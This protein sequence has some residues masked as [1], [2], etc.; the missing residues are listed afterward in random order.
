EVTKGAAV[1][2]SGPLS[3]PVPH[4]LAAAAVGH[5]GQAVVIGI[6]PED[7]Y[8]RQIANGVA[9]DARIA[10]IEALGPETVVVAEIGGVE[11]SARLG[12]LFT[13]PIGSVQRFYVDPD[14]I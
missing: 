13:A 12:R 10:A 4:G 1:L 5:A 11:I 6:R 7:I 9:L 8:D 3:L 14:Q 2:R